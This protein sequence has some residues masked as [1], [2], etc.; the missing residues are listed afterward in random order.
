MLLFQKRLAMGAAMDRIQKRWEKLRAHWKKQTEVQR[1]TL[2]IL[3]VL[4]AVAIAFS[5][6]S[7]ALS[8]DWTG[9][10][11]NMG[12]ELGGAVVTFILIDRIVRGGEEKERD[13]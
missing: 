6:P 5:L 13:K 12:T 9:L 4:V 11:L 8:G 1:K 3:G 10:F 7:A 2:L